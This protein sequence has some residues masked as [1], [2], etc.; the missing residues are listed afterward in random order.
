V[1]EG[2]GVAFNG[3][4][5]GDDVKAILFLS[6]FICFYFLSSFLSS[7]TFSSSSS[8]PPAFYNFPLFFFYDLHFRLIIRSSSPTIFSGHSLLHSFSLTSLSFSPYCSSF[9]FRIFVST[10]TV[11]FQFF[12][13]FL[14]SMY[15]F[16]LFLLFPSFHTSFLFH[17]I[18]S[19]SFLLFHD[20]YCDQLKWG[21]TGWV[22][23]EAWS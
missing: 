2:G 3:S 4:K 23:E 9:F 17:F 16:M 11:F 14:I 19:S 10:V 15:S 20:E 21:L 7:H 22:R 12:L 13:S 6:P 1:E 5:T 8:P 18:Y